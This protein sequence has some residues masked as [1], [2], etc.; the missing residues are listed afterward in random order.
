MS[1]DEY[2]DLVDE[3]DNV[4]GKMRRSQVYAESRTN[5]RVVNAFIVNEGGLLWIP[6]RTADKRVFPCCLDMSMGGH[7][8]SGEHYHEAFRRELREELNLD[9]EVCSYRLMG[10]LTPHGHHVSA[11]MQVY[12]VRIRGEVAYNQADFTEAF[13]MTPQEVLDRLAA[14]DKSKDDLPRLIWHFY[15]IN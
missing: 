13:W 9:P 14:G 11:F 10:K 12:E 7:V 4:I 6:R 1:N 8:E 2:L 15:P 3:G 5:F